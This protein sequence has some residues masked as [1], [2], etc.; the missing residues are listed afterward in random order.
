MV[1]YQTFFLQLGKFV[2][3][4]SRIALP[5]GIFLY[6]YLAF[7]GREVMWVLGLRHRTPPPPNLNTQLQKRAKKQVMRRQIIVADG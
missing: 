6:T 1:A 3:Y 7:M 2:L 5:L 4:F